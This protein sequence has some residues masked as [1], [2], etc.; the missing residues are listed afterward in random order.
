MN[1]KFPGTTIPLFSSCCWRVNI[2]KKWYK[3]NKNVR[4]QNM[5]HIEQKMFGMKIAPNLT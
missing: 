5:F 2:S 4:E 1:Q 3:W